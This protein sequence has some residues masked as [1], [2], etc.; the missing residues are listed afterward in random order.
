MSYPWTSEAWRQIRLRAG[1]GPCALL[2]TGPRG[3]GKRDLANRAAQ[4]MLC[5]QA[6]EDGPACGACSSCRL[7]LADNHPDFR[8][9]APEED[10]VEA[11]DEAPTEAKPAASRW[12]KIEQIRALSEFIHLSSHLRGLRVALVEP[13]ERMQHASANALLK[14]LEEPPAQMR[15][16]LVSD[17]P[18]R[19]LATVRS[20]CVNIRLRLPPAAEARAWLASQGTAQARLALAQ[21]GDAPLAAR[22][23]DAPEY[24]EQRRMLLGALARRPVDACAIAEGITA[25]LLA[26]LLGHLWRWCYDLYSLR[27]GGRIRY[28]SDSAQILA[29]I[30]DNI[31]VNEFSEFLT[32]LVQAQRSA[33]HPLNPRLAAEQLLLRY[34]RAVQGA[35]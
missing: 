10:L 2:L 30:A 27:L 31:S 4:A 13:A 19:L 1:Q 28:N 14:M 35:S 5:A 12:I 7:F 11:G 8:R 17:N 32:Q 16:L 15:F 22:D 23:L 33:E 9:L 21:A 25:P 26:P 29:V 34:A 24:W 18:S 6:A 20:R 3:V